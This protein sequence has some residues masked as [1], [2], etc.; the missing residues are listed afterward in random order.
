M[1]SECH[2]V[3]SNMLHEHVVSPLGYVGNIVDFSSDLDSMLDNM[4]T[5]VES[6]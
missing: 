4:I 1:Y 3:R 2:N 6:H 5:A